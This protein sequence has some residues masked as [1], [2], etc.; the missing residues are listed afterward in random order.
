M[1]PSSGIFADINCPFEQ[2]G[3]CERPHCIYKHATKSWDTCGGLSKSSIVDLTGTQYDSPYAACGEP[4]N[5]GTTGNYLHDL[6]RINKEIETVR[7]QVEQEQRRL[8][9]YQTI[10]ADNKNDAPI[11]KH[12]TQVRT[13]K[14]SNKEQKVKNQQSLEI[15]RPADC[16]PSNEIAPAPYQVPISRSPSPELL[17]DSNED[18][19]LIIDDPLSPVEISSDVQRPIVSLVGKSSQNMEEVR[20]GKTVPDLLDCTS[21]KLKAADVLDVTSSSELRYDTNEVY[22]CGDNNSPPTFGYGKEYKKAPVDGSVVA[23][24][25]WSYPQ[26]ELSCTLEKVNPFSY[27]VPPANSPPMQHIKQILTEQPAQNRV[28]SHKSPVQS[29]ESHEQ[30]NQKVPEGLLQKQGNINHVS[31]VTC[32]V[33]AEPPSGKSQFSTGVSSVHPLMS[34]RAESS[35]QLFIYENEPVIIINSSSEDE[36]KGLNYSDLELSDSDPMEECY[37]IFMEAN[38]EDK[39]NQEHPDETVGANMDV[40][41]PEGDVKLQPLPGKKRMAHEAQHIESLAKRRP[42]PQIL[43]PLQEPAAS[44]FVSNPTITSKI[45]QVQQKAST[46]TASVKASQAF[47]SSTSQRKPEAQSALPLTQ[48]HGNLQ[49]PPVQNAYLNYIPLGTAVIEVGNNLHLILPQSGFPPSAASTSTPVT[50]VLTPVGQVHPNGVTLKQAY[51][52]LTITPLPRY[53]LTAPVLIAPP[54]R[55][56]ALN[57]GFASTSL[58]SKA[59]SAAPQAAVQAAAKPVPAKRKLRQQ[60]EAA[61]DKVP[62]DVRQRYVNMFTEEFLKTTANVNEAFEKALAEEKTV[63]NRSI[64]KL[65]YLSVAVN[66]LKKLKNQSAAAAKTDEKQGNSQKSKG[67]I[68]LNPLKMKGNDEMTLY[69]ILQDYVLSDEKMI[70]NNFPVPHPEKRGSAVLFNDKKVNTESL[71]RICCRCG[72][73]Y[74][75]SQTGKHIRKEECN[76]H[77]GKGVEKRVPGGLETRYSCCQGV[78]GAPGCQVFKLHVHD[79]LNLDGFVST[80]SRH[81]SDKSCPGVYSLACEMCYTIHGLEVSRVTV[82]NSNVQVIYDTFVKPDNEVID[83]NTRF[84]GISEEDVKDNHTSLKE[85]Q[86][87]LLSFISADTILIGHGLETDLCLLKLLHGMVVDTSVVFPH[88]LG[89]PHKLSLNSLTADY[90]RRIIQESVCGHDTAEDAAAC[91]E[92]MLW[93]LKEDGKLKK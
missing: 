18:S 92:L 19:I 28:H 32:Q 76:Y 13:R 85:V 8:S 27:K 4:V 73:T 72:A 57:S 42:Q 64:N 70:E 3:L 81:P 49:P 58:H 41:K 86:E 36:E 16:R 77:Y 54:V 35:E 82:V 52:P 31:P 26:S 71:K 67:S 2:L 20:K 62:H 5:D 66:A 88:R 56:P 60:C 83:Y 6:E 11:S 87:N 50:S 44:K 78:M 89:P 80:A 25:E 65:K 47:V 29:V 53:R 69:E 30:N 10:Q 21:K 23:L 68:P 45:Q 22:N 33:R 24:N 93:K 15:S 48:T 1:F 39:K 74:S 79:S 17:D 91:M 59:A 90:L 46:L 40:E 84:S 14:S 63:Y 75:V 51:H 9:C 34:N 43:V 37:R 38:Q 12:T 7:H 61:K 55:R